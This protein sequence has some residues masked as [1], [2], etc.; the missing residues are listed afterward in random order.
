MRSERITRLRE[1]PGG[2]SRSLV[3]LYAPPFMS[4]T[5]LEASW[6]PWRDRRRRRR[7][8]G[9]PHVRGRL[10]PP[11]QPGISRYVTKNNRGRA[12]PRRIS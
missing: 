10:G 6:A 5:P 11:R 3:G 9:R 7:P 1:P 12:R 4:L 2:G 8:E